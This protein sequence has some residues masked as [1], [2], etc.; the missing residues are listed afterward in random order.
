MQVGDGAEP[1]QPLAGR[2]QPGDGGG[3]LPGLAQLAGFCDLKLG[4]QGLGG[5][6]I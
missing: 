2:G 6:A 1:A 4:E 5:V 3:W